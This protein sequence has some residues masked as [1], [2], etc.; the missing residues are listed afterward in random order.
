LDGAQRAGAIAEVPSH[1]E[2]GA[3]RAGGGTCGQC[4]TRQHCLIGGL[5]QSVAGLGPRVRERSFRRGDMLL[6]EGER[7]ARLRLV[8]IGTVFVCRAHSGG[9]THP[10]GIGA[11]GMVLGL[12][13][14][15]KQPNQTSVIGSTAGRYCEVPVPCVEALA[16]ND[17]LFRERLGKAFTD[18]IAFMARWA[19]LRGHRGV[20]AQV[21]GSLAI[22]MEEQRTEAIDV[23]SH[24]AFARMLGTTRESVARA[25]AGLE[26]AGCLVRTAARRCTV[27]GRALREW[28]AANA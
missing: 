2:D 17:P 6:R 10:L 19:Q 9:S 23:P 12:C 14:Y 1:Q 26:R 5:P 15:A 20:V 27:N 28:L 22:I 25:M 8:K 3:H 13:G 7:E 21:A 11:R 16:Q 4:A 18:N 24:M